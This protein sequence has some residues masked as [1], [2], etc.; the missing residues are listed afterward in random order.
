VVV[1]I[2]QARARLGFSSEPR[3]C[4]PTEVRAR[5]SQVPATM[6]TVVSTITVRHA[7]KSTPNTVITPAIGSEIDL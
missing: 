4:R 6:A 2:P 3:T 5:K 1:E 7:E